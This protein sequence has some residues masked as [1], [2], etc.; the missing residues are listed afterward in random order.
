MICS[1]EMEEERKVEIYKVVEGEV[2]FDVDAQKETIWATQAQIAQLFD[3]NP[4]AITRHL[5]HIYEEGELEELATCSILE[6]VR[7]EGDKEGGRVV[8]RKVKKYNLD[9]IIS[10]GYRVNSR[11]ATDFRIWATKTLHNYVVDGV[12]INERRLMELDQKKL[13]E[14][15]SAVGIVKRLMLTA[16]LDAGEASGVLEI[17]ANYA[18][19]FETI[20][21]YQVGKI[22]FGS[23][24]RGRMRLDELDYQKYVTNLRRS[25]EEG[26]EFGKERLDLGKKLTEL[27]ENLK[28]AK[29]A[30]KAAE[31]LWLL[32]Q[33]QPFEKGNEEIAALIFIAF[34]TLNDYQLTGKGE[35]K[36]SDR[37]LTALVLLIK[38]SRP[39]EKELMVALICKLLD[40]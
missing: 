4:Q 9:A 6:Q 29:I 37:A 23:G 22:K 33:E 32:V 39:A 7:V 20:K 31:L 38:E 2:V 21:E 30:K 8:R 10:V 36:L 27:E 19:S 11:K 14:I 26:K 3:V 24:R 40:N 5:K 25:R 13:R 35:T 16:E 17:I 12:A 34:L 1:G 18:G 28:E 15:E